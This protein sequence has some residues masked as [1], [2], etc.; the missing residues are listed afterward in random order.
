MAITGSRGERKST[1]E[2]DRNFGWSIGGIPSGGGPPLTIFAG[3]TSGEGW[4]AEG[5]RGTVRPPGPHAVSRS[6]IVA[7]RVAARI[8]PINR[9]GSAAGC[10]GLDERVGITDTDA[11]I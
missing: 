4:P 7:M 2:A 3:S 10:L 1:F 6:P 8:P 5:D 11:S 9:E